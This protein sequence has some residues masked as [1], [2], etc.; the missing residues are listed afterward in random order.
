MRALAHDPHHNNAVFLLRNTVFGDNALLRLTNGANRHAVGRD[1]QLVQNLNHALRTALGQVQVVVSVANRVGVALD[2]DLT[3]IGGIVSDGEILTIGNQSFFGY[4]L[5][6]FFRQC[7][8]Q[9]TPVW[10][11]NHTPILP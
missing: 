2:Y 7:A 10:D 3:A 9:F 5:T 8:T 6:R 11:R 4:L 1:V